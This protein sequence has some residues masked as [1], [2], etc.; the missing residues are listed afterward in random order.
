MQTLKDGKGTRI[1]ARQISPGEP[2]R[3]GPIRAEG[4]V[5]GELKIFELRK[6]FRLMY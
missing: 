4:S 3:P 5:F 1:V 2:G 6:V